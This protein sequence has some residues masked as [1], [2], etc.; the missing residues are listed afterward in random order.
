MPASCSEI[1][2]LDRQVDEMHLN[3][4]KDWVVNGSTSEKAIAQFG[5]ENCFKVLPIQDYYWEEY[6]NSQY[7]ASVTVDRDDLM[8]VRSLIY[9]ETRMN[10]INIG[11][12]VCNKS[13]ANDLLAIFRTLYEAK[14]NVDTMMPLAMSNYQ[15]LTEEANASNN[16]TFCFHFMGNP[17]PEAHV[18][19]GV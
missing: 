14:Y 1:E 15:S 7:E 11:E 19:G 2:E 16:D 13:I 18:K 3:N 9:C 5:Y 6:Q 4:L 17:L 8:S 12:I 10:H